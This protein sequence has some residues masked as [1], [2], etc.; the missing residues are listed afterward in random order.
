MIY[1]LFLILI[2]LFII[3][4][5]IKYRI[6]IDFPSFFE[7][8]FKALRGWFGVYCFCGK[9]GTGK[10]FATVLFLLRNQNMPIYSNIHLKDIKHTYY[11]TF[12]EMLQIKDHDCI[13]VFDEI[14][15]ALSKG[16]PLTKEVLSFLSQQRKKNVI[17]ITTAQEW[18]EIPIT[19]RRYVR[20]QIDCSIWNVLPFSILVQRYRNGEEMK[21]SNDDNEYIAPIISTKISKMRKRVTKN[22]D[23]FETVA[24]SATTP[25]RGVA[26][27]KLKYNPYIIK[28]RSTI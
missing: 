2:L 20:F 19:L 13:I 24:L 27:T 4:I 10:T 11:S 26:D 25:R 8:G 23:T 7:K 18:L 16:S 28:N 14:F 3:I 1:S 6:S 15:T 12:E 5:F 21:W 22:Y 9:Q 17:F